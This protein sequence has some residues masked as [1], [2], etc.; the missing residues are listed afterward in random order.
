M[1]VYMAAEVVLVENSVVVARHTDWPVLQL[2]P[3]FHNCYKSAARQEQRYRS[4]GRCG[5][6]VP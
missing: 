3:V 4:L 1:V 5:V 6:I 2:P